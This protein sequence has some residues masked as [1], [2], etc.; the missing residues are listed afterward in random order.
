MKKYAPGDQIIVIKSVEIE[1]DNEEPENLENLEAGDIIM[2]FDLDQRLESYQFIIRKSG[3]TFK[4]PI[5]DF[6]EYNSKQKCFTKIR[7]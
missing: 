6:H 1:L 7:I 5:E 4:W 3:N 2:L